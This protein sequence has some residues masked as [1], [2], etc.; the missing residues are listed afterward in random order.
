MYDDM[1]VHIP[2]F[3]DDRGEMLK[4]IIINQ[5]FGNPQMIYQNTET[6]LKKSELVNGA[7]TLDD[8]IRLREEISKKCTIDGMSWNNALDE[9]L[10]GDNRMATSEGR[11]AIK[12]DGFTF[13]SDDDWATRLNDFNA[14]V[15][16]KRDSYVRKPNNNI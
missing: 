14:V 15:Q 1:E 16:L 4:D 12:Y 6:I 8:A 13:V 11:Y 10:S 3:N 9:V 2:C 5:P 7:L